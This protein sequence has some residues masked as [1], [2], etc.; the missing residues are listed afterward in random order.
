M[1]EIALLSA[2]M[3]ESEGE[4]VSVTER[5]EKETK[6]EALLHVCFS[7]ASHKIT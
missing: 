7:A 5:R 3:C 2:S 1:L 4:G 6:R